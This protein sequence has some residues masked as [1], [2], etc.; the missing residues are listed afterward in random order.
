LFSLLLVAE[1]L[2]ERLAPLFDVVNEGGPV[3][4]LMLRV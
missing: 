3:L 4:V 1:L 2:T